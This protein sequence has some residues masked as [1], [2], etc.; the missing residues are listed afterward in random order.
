MVSTI[1]VFYFSY[2]GLYVY[3]L[4]I[5]SSFGTTLWSIIFH[6]LM[7]SS[8]FSFHFLL[9]FLLTLFHFSQLFMIYGKIKNFQGSFDIRF[10]NLTFSYKLLLKKMSKW[11]T[12]NKI[13]PHKLNSI[14]IINNNNIP[15]YLTS[16]L[17]EQLRVV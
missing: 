16:V 13:H 10:W 14:R 6:C 15:F 7:F 17:H 2:L 4:P 3:C 8:T 1:F 5:L 11:N 9:P 12:G